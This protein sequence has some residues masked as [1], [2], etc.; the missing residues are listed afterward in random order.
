MA[1][2]G[3]FGFTSAMIMEEKTVSGKH[4]AKKACMLTH[5]KTALENMQGLDLIVLL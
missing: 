3:R 1:E 4:L 5:G 2:I